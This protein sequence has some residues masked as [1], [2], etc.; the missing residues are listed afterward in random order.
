[1]DEYRLVANGKVSEFDGDLDDYAKRVLAGIEGT[2][3][4]VAVDPTASRRDDRRERAQARA[5]SAPL[6]KT[7]QRLERELAE[8]EAHRAKLEL[9]LADTAFYERASADEV[10]DKVNERGRLASRIAEVEDAW[11]EA[12]AEVEAAES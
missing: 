12:Q 3:T 6:R 10:R 5:R 8:L 4:S 1:C 2:E 9:E 7:T 11:L